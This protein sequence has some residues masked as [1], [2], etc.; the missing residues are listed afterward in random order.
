[1]N[2]GNDQVEI[3]V[4]RN[5]TSQRFLETQ[6]VPIVDQ[7]GR[8]SVGC[9][10]GQSAHFLGIPPDDGHVIANLFQPKDPPRQHPAAADH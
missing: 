5:R 4:I 8:Q 3:S 6:V 9:L 7:Y 10:F 1:M 2:P